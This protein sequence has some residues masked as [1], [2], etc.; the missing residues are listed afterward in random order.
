MQTGAG[1]DLAIGDGG[2]NSIA[3]NM[4]L[5][6]IYQI[7]RSLR[8]NATI[9]SEWA[10]S[11]DDFGFTFTSDFDLYPNPQRFVDSQSSFVDQILTY[12][13]ISLETNSVRDIVG[14]SSIETTSS[15]CMKPMFRVIPGYVSETNVLAG[16]DIV[17]SDG[18]KDFLIGDDVRGFSAVDLSEF[19]AIQDTRQELDDLVVDLSVRL[20]TLGYDTE[21]YQRLVLGEPS[22]TEYNISVGCDTMTTNETST[23]L[24]TG[25]SLTI[26]GRTFLGS[27]F[28]NPS[29]QVPQL[30]E[31]IRDVQLVVTD[32]HFALYE[33]HLELL[34]RVQLVSEDFKEGQSPSHRLYLADDTI[35]SRGSNDI[36]SGDSAVFYVQI[37]SPA[38]G[39]AFDVLKDNNMK[40]VLDGIMTQRQAELDAHIENELLPSEPLSNQEENGLAFDDVPFYLSIG[41]D[42]ISVYD[43][44]VLVSGD[45]ATLGTAYSEESSSGNQEQRALAKYTDSI[46]ITRL[47]PSVSAFLPRLAVYKIGFFYERYGQEVRKEV[48]PTYHGDVFYARS[49]KNIV[50]GDFLSAP[51]YGFDQSG[52]YILDVKVNFYGIYENAEWAIYFDA[53]TMNVLSET[54]SPIFIRQKINGEVSGTISKAKTDP[55]VESAMNLF[56]GQ[57]SIARQALSDLY[58]YSTVVYPVPEDVSL[59]PFCNA[60]DP[61]FSYIPSHTLSIYIAGVEPE[62]EISPRNVTGIGEPVSALTTDQIFERHLATQLTQTSDIDKRVEGSLARPYESQHTYLRYNPDEKEV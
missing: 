23:A 6:R 20:S 62:I 46:E 59:R 39:Y 32:L 45:F 14:I 9:E 47:K 48:E 27:Y 12:D 5:P 52:E 36:V 8:T 42:V 2:S 19:Q 17:A 3:A 33:I 61:S 26:M 18:G 56:F 4:D 28:P 34:R 50:F 40:K 49:S 30:L 11:A 53:D 15:Y 38:E 35:Q 54:E 1:N 44:D 29:D 31:R 10:P 24:V 7:Y 57:Q 58:L 55:L 43:N 37:D 25:D 16:N 41:N 13:D 22:G 51:T 21:H 60:D